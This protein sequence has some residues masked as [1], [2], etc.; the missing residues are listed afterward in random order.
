MS[1]FPCSTTIWLVNRP[2]NTNAPSL[3]LPC[4]S[5]LQSSFFFAPAFAFRRGHFLPGFLSSS[6]HLSKRPLHV[7]LPTSPLVSIPRL[8]QPLDGF[9]RSLVSQACFILQPRAR[10]LLFRG[11][12]LRTVFLS[13][14]KK[15]PP[16]RFRSST[17]LPKLV[18]M[19]LAF[20]FE[21]FTH[22]K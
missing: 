18:S 9:L 3:I 13:H 14:R 22:T 17:Y 4:R 5:P 6:R 2:L 19:L 12:S 15:L 7:R 21:A 10:F 11:F 16:C 1:L 8:S 20:D